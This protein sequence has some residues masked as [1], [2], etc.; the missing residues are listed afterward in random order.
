MSDNELGRFLRERREATTPAEVGL[1]AGPRRRTPGLRRSEVATLAGVS[2]DYLTRLEQGRDQ[3][4]SPEVLNALATALG[5]SRA[6]RENLR[7]LG[8]A[9]SGVMCP[10]GHMPGT[11]VRPTVR[12]LL[13]R[14]E[15]GPAV[16]LNRLG[17]VLAATSGYDAL[18]R[19]VGLFDGRRH[20]IVR[21]VMVDPRARDVFPDWGRV[22]E[23]HIAQLKSEV[24][25]GD[26][27]AVELAGDL[28]VLV[29]AEFTERMAAP[30]GFPERSG[31]ELLAHPEVGLLRLAFEVL[32][33]PDADEQRLIV[34]LPADEA[35]RV[36]LDRLSGRRPGALRAV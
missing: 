15:P 9:A 6:D 19:P 26:P 32:D 17:D 11:E 20:N 2:V 5:F 18:F 33:L 1:P 30:G 13:G 29:G 7:W 10:A 22:A 24:R 3:R 25:R 8:K 16:V 12:A 34:H 31:V 28:T 14:L 23:G 4:P 36:A 21:F 35:T 27:H